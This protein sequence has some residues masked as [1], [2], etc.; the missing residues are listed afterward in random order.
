MDSFGMAVFV[1]CLRYGRWM[2]VVVAPWIIRDPGPPRALE[3]P[4]AT[5][6]RP[7]MAFQHA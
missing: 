1:V 3:V 5:I 4:T 6:C 7:W 2:T